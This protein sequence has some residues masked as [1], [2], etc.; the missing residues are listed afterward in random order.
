LV[1]YIEVNSLIRVLAVNVGQPVVIQE[2]RGEPVFSGIEKLRL[3][4]GPIEVGLTNI[5]GDRQADLVNHGGPDKAVY[6]YPSEHLGYWKDELGYD[7]GDSGFG[8]NL[9][10]AGALEADSCIGDVWRWGGVT[11]QIAQPRWPCFKLAHR[12]GHP[13]MVKRFVASGRSGWYLRV[14]EVG[15]SSED[16]PI[17]IVERDPAGISVHDA[18][19]AAIHRNSL[20]DAERERYT[21]HPALSAA[22]RDMLS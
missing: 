1:S 20:S 2:R 16:T 14:L 8:E 11:L 22:W 21:S 15:V 6:V 17:E 18:F 9:T 10:I 13:D 19:A 4:V 12:T 3:P 7:G 5:V